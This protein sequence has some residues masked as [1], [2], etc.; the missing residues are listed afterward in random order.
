MTISITKDGLLTTTFTAMQRAIALTPKSSLVPV[1]VVKR[2]DILL[3][4]VQ[5]SLQSSAS[6]AKKR[7]KSP[8]LC[9]YILSDASAR[10]LSI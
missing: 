4:N 8:G 1:V 5:T 9:D 7:V 10:P 2:K 3:L 6:T